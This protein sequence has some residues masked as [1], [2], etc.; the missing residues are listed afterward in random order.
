VT[1]WICEL[2]NDDPTD[3]FPSELVSRLADPRILLV[4]HECNLGAV[5]TFNLFYRSIAEPFYTILEDDNWFDLQFLEKMLDAIA[6]FPDATLAWCNQHVWQELPDGS[7]KD[8][9]RSVN[10]SEPFDSPPRPVRWGCP[11]QVMGGIHANGAMLMRSRSGENYATPDIPLAGVE[12]YRERMFPYPL[13]Y[14]PQSLANFAQ[15]LQTARND[16][17]SAFGAFQVALSASFVRHGSFNE[18]QLREIWIYFKNQ[19]P[20]MTNELL[21]AA[22][23][24]Q[25][26]RLFIRFASFADWARF[27]LN[28]GRHPWSSFHKLRI[29]TEHPNWWNELDRL[30]AARFAEAGTDSKDHLPAGL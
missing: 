6:A 16:A 26:A 9:G 3:R 14:V 27:L 28:A 18:P 2:H 24:C 12:A 30:T 13:V 10:P 29:H 7:W 17:A 20:P 19:H 25:E 1:D 11:R 5:A 21:A 23:I 4:E 22:L 8:S 15:T